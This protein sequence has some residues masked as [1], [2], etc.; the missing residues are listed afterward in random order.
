MSTLILPHALDAAQASFRYKASHTN[1]TKNNPPY[2]MDMFFEDYPFFK[3]GDK[4]PGCDRVEVPDDFIQMHIDYANDIVR[5]NL[6]GSS[7]RYI[8]GLVV[9]HLLI[10]YLKTAVPIGSNPDRIVTAGSPTGLATSKSVD[11]VS[12][13]YDY[14]YLG[15]NANKYGAWGLTLY[16]IQFMTFARAMNKGGAYIW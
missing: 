8:C 7:W 4:I 6:Y 2:T 16:G 15:V 11:G 13:S 9:A 12:I 14:S 1:I 5:Q 3:A 10:M